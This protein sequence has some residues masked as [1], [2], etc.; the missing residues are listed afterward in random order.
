VGRRVIKTIR[1]RK[2]KAWII[3][4]RRRKINSLAIR[5]GITSIRRARIIENNIRTAW[6]RKIGRR[7]TYIKRDLIIEIRRRKL[8]I[9]WNVAEAWVGKN[10][11]RKNIIWIIRIVKVRSRKN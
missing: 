7:E 8:K 4:I 11:K 10:R 6:V 5:G 9:I 3:K 1:R 2:N